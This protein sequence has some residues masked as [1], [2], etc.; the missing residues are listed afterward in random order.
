MPPME[1]D[2]HCWAC[3]QPIKSAQRYCLECKSWQ[4]WR[5]HLNLSTSTL[6]LIVALL[7]VT[8]TL[9]PLLRVEASAAY[10]ILSGEKSIGASKVKLAIFA[11]N[12]GNLDTLLDT[13][14]HCKSNLRNG[15]PR[16]FSIFAI[17][18]R[19]VGVGQKVSIEYA[20]K[21]VHHETVMGRTRC[22]LVYYDNHLTKSFR[23]VEVIFTEGAPVIFE[24]ES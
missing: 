11:K 9:I 5:R 1:E 24:H 2:K 14:I 4:N 20:G 13:V 18:D 6:S 3:L 7:A 10:L 17:G 16:S 8:S 15:D 22:E 19:H 21:L 12:V 23:R